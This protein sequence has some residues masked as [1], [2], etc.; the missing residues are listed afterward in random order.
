MLGGGLERA[1]PNSLGKH[2]GRGVHLV[3]DLDA[4]GVDDVPS[5]GQ[6]LAQRSRTG[7][8][9]TANHQG[10]TPIALGPGQLAAAAG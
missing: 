1:D 3:G 7:T 2:P 4:F 5:P 10:R 9:G 6:D 8:A